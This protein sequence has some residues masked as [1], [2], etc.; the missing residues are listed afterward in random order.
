M[1]MPPRLPKHRSGSRWLIVP[2][3][4]T[5]I[6]V[7]IDASMHARSP[8]PQ[9]T[10]DSEAWVDQVLPDITASSAQGLEIA[11][12][13]SRK[14]T[15]P[16]GGVAAELSSL[17]SQSLA[18]YRSVRDLAPPSG[19]ASA[20]GLLQACLWARQA[21][22]GEMASAVKQLLGGAHPYS[23]VP[24]MTAAAAE[25]QVSDNAYQ[26]FS[27]DLPR[28]GVDM[29]PS[30]WAAQPG[31]FQPEALSGF[32]ARLLADVVKAPAHELDID[33]I[34]TN[35]AVLDTQGNVQVLSPA[36][37][38][39]VT[40]VVADGG[41]SSEAGVTVSARIS[42]A[43]GSPAQDVSATVNLSQG[44]AD[45]VTL[46]GLRTMPSTPTTLTVSAVGPDGVPSEVSRQLQIEV[47][48]PN[49]HGVATTGAPGTATTTEVPATTEPTG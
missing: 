39:S 48:G 7:L 38:V 35:P 12:I 30:Q 43:K 26:L 49:F 27:R 15:L 6:V 32:T 47:P 25:F 23:V 22:A 28:L 36:E 46:S 33:A 9:R 41:R 14:L 20:A 8:Q 17:A 44:Q 10:L 34:S 45:A 4:L 3:V 29:P 13:S 5:I 40:V 24:E 19:L 37:T 42:P 16:A 21:G 18:T 11:G 31:I 1:V 2:F